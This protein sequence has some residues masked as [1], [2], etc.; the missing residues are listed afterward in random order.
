MSRRNR[1]VAPP[2]PVDRDLLQMLLTDYNEAVQTLDRAATALRLRESRLRNVLSRARA[3]SSDPG[4]LAP[5]LVTGSAPT[6]E[7]AFFCL[8]KFKVEVQGAGLDQ[9]PRA[10][11]LKILKLLVHRQGHPATREALAEA[12]WPDSDPE[13][14][15]N[16]LRVSIHSLRQAFVKWAH[17]KDVIVYDGGVYGLNPQLD[18]WVDADEFEQ[19]WRQG[20]RLDTDGLPREAMLSYQKA[21]MV[22]QGDYLEDDPYDEWTF[23]RRERLRDAYLHLLGKL[24]AGYFE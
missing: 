10:K 14:A 9:Q 17:L 24:A 12:L 11:A 22:Y 13:V 1:P 8:G 4:S 15:F 2:L 6:S 16:R 18:L 3:P 23:L 5:T 20:V 7:I 19:R 21:E